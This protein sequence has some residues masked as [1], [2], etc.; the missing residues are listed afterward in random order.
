MARLTYD[1]MNELKDKYNVDT[2]Y[3]YSR[4]STFLETPWEYRVRYLEKNKVDTSN[5][6]TVFGTHV[7]DSLEAYYNGE[8]KKEDLLKDFD[9]FVIDWQLLSNHKFPS[10]NIEKGY[11]ENIRHYFKTFEPV[12]ANTKTEV[13][14]KV[15]VERDGR[16]Y[17]LVGY[18]DMM[19]G[20]VVDGEPHVYILDF[21]T[22]SKGGFSGESL[23]EK[24]KQLMVYALGVYQQ[25]K[26]KIKAENIHIGFDMIKYVTKEIM[27]ANG[28]WGKPALVERRKIVENIE[29]KARALMLKEDHSIPDMDNIIAK[30]KEDDTIE[31]LPDSIREQ[32]RFTNGYIFLDMDEETMQ[33]TADWFVDTVHRLQEAIKGDWDKEFPVPDIT[34]GAPDSFYYN[35]LAYGLLQ[36]HPDHLDAIALEEAMRSQDD[37]DYDDL[38]RLFDSLLE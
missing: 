3:S 1:E 16:N 4:L 15:V 9:D 17:V 7:H 29:N 25:G 8:K 11:I 19:W 31:H 36:F 21:K 30:C 32:F 13:T 34:E 27:K 23:R 28:D 14:T 12:E 26:G 37:A 6:Y 2:I 38:D 35:N 20:K 10:E 18:I 5:V 24:A 33:E 22:S